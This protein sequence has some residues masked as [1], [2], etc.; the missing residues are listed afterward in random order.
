MSIQKLPLKSG[1][2]SGMPEYLPASLI[3]SVAI[4]GGFSG[5][6]CTVSG[7]YVTPCTNSTQTIACFLD[8]GTIAAA[9]NDASGKYIRPAVWF[10]STTVFI[11]PCTGA[12]PTIANVGGLYDLTISSG[13]QY[14]NLAASTHDLVRVVGFLAGTTAAASYVL[15]QMNNKEFYG[16]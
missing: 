9:D 11:V 4:Q 2:Y 6:F 8:S 1:V 14:V 13:I 3:T 5:R 12:V 10:D 7:G 16:G 15:V